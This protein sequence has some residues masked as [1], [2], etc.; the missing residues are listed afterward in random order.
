M[1]RH[2]FIAVIFGSTLT[3]AADAQEG[4][5]NG[6]VLIVR[7][8]ENGGIGRS[9]A[10]R[11]EQRA[12]AYKDY[13]LNF[14]VDSKRLEPNVIFAAKDSKQSHRPRLT[15]EPFAK[16]AKLKID[17]R[18]GNNQSGELAADLRANQQGKVILISWRHPYIP[19]LLGALG[20][21]PKSFLPNGK[22]PDSTYDWVIILSYDQDGRLIPGSSRR[23]NEHLMP[24][25]S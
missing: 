15:V 12:E 8:A 14:T 5:K 22:W 13:F 10:P 11:G 2:L 24:G 21:N 4:P 19:A 1:H 7:H 23:I 3:L 17:T 20:A 18:F 6:I 9:L 16:A 25:D